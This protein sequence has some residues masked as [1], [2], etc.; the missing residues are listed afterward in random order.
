MY[1]SCLRLMYCRRVHS[2][3]M[4]LHEYFNNCMCD[5]RLFQWLFEFLILCVSSS[6][7]YCVLA[8]VYFGSSATSGIRRRLLH[9]TC[10]QRVLPR[11]E[12]PVNADLHSSGSWERRKTRTVDRFV[13]D[14]EYQITVNAT[15]NHRDRCQ[16]DTLVC[17]RPSVT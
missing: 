5:T 17:D 3:T 11:S 4:S 2:F 12:K 13:D 1:D 10:N 9:F 8:R 15:Q 6:R 7:S 14:V 16:R